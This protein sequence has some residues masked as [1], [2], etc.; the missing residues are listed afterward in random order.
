[1]PLQEG[2]LGRDLHGETFINGDG[3]WGLSLGKPTGPHNGG[4]KKFNL[5][6]L[7]TLP[8]VAQRAEN[9]M[10]LPERLEQVTFILTKSSFF[11]AAFA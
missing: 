9:A 11:V 6:R 3:S 1:L 10:P 4:T 5:L 8:A 7:S 2:I